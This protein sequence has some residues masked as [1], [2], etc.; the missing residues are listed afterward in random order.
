M[1]W[2][3]KINKTPALKIDAKLTAWRRDSAVKQKSTSFRGRAKFKS[4]P[5]QQLCVL[6]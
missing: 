1:L 6:P 3:G 2:L 5:S 4:S